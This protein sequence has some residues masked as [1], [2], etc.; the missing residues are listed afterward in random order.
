MIFPHH[1]P[2]IAWIYFF[3]CIELRDGRRNTKMRGDLRST[4]PDG[5]KVT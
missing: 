5:I 3:R 2:W 4:L 1:H